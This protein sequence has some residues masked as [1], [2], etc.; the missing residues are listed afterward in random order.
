MSWTLV[1]QHHHHHHPAIIYY[2]SCHVDNGFKEGRDLRKEILGQVDD[3]EDKTM[4]RSV[5]VTASKSV[6]QWLLNWKWKQT[7]KCRNDSQMDMVRWL[8]QC[9]YNISYLKPFLRAQQES[10]PADEEFVLS[11]W[12]QQFHG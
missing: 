12:N 2:V 6:K 5:R 7:E 1:P 8:Q 9:L 3:P 10:T 11:V 4:K